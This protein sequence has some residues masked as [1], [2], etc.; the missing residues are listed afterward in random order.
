MRRRDF[1]TELGGAAL[2]WPLAARA[3]PK[4]PVIG[5]LHTTHLEPGNLAA[6]ERALNETG[7]VAGQNVAIEHRSAEAQYDRLPAMAADLVRRQVNVLVAAG[8]NSALAAKAATAT[9]PIVFSG[10][11]DPV[12]LGLVDSFNR[13]GGNVTGVY[14]VEAS[15]E[16]KRLGLLRELVPTAALIAVLHNPSNANFEIGV[17]D[18]EQGARSVGQQIHLLRASTEQDID[19]AFATMVQLRVGAL[20]IS[21]DPLF[22]L[23]RVQFAI[24]AARHA[25]PAMYSRREDALAGGLISY[26]PSPIEQYR[27]MGLYTGR[28]LKGAKPADL[29]IFQSIKFELVINLKTAK[30][31][32]LEMPS[33]LSAIADE[34]IE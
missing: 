16:A 19:T 32:G 34:V 12:K 9:I 26:G 30:T 17:N 6:F 20:L 31:L 8:G 15:M 24:L 2:A 10:G 18:V 1:I 29:P 7:F 27:Q 28:I 23:R 11:G 14:I 5:F 22:T 3:Q 33:G 13:P 21:S 25:I 4:V